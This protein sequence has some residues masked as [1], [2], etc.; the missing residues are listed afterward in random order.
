MKMK[1]SVRQRTLSRRQSNNLQKKKR[2]LPT[3][4]VIVDQDLKYVFFKKLKK[5]DIKKKT[6]NLT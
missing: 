5:L 3:P 2:F 4:Y 1:A 6:N